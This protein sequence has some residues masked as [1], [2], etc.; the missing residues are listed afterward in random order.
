M[1]N[2]CEIAK[3]PERDARMLRYLNSMFDS[4]LVEKDKY[5][6][7]DRLVKSHMTGM[8]ACKDMVEALIGMPVNLQL[9][10]N[11]TLGF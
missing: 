8:L 11:L 3:V 7:D 4:W 6:M 9:D 10:G 2:A 5:G 1:L